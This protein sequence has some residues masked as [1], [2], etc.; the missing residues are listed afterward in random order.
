MVKTSVMANGCSAL[1]CAH[2]EYSP[3]LSKKSEEGAEGGSSEE[4]ESQATT[5]A[6]ELDKRYNNKDTATDD[7][8][9][10]SDGDDN[11]ATNED[12]LDSELGA[13]SQPSHDDHTD[14]HGIRFRKLPAPMDH[15]TKAIPEDQQRPLL[16]K[17]KCLYDLRDAFHQQQLAK[18]PETDSDQKCVCFW[19]VRATNESRKARPRRETES[20]VPGSPRNLFYLP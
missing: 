15:H 17:K 20:P 14:R 16:R 11:N 6:A 13:I 1:R 8:D 18:N 10:D 2:R 7:D 19:S 9:D 4:E 5:K 3:F 12:A